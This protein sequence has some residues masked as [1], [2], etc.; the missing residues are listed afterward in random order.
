MP[1]NIYDQ[2]FQAQ[3]MNTYVPMPYQEI[4]QAGAMKQERHDLSEELRED[5]DDQLMNPCSILDLK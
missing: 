3:Y 4:L 5:L 1:V 2:P